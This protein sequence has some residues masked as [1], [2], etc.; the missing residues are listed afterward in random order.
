MT[1]T[2]RQALEYLRAAVEERG[3][4]YVYARSNQGRLSFCTYERGGQPSCIVGEVLHRAGVSIKQLKKLD[5]P[6]SSGIR[7]LAANG[8]L[9]IDVELEAVERL[10][11]LQ[12]L[13]D[14][15]ET[16]GFVLQRAEGKLV[17]DNGAW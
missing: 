1:L 7:N 10:S 11:V 16:W 3:E 14:S 17:P 15:G 8:I 12:A 9:P 2:W 4:D 5:M 13:Q 6:G